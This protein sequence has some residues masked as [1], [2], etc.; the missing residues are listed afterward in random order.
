[1]Q[2]GESQDH[3]IRQACRKAVTH[4]LIFWLIVTL[5]LAAIVAY[6]GKYWRN[7]FAGPYPVTSAQLATMS[8]LAQEP[9][10]FVKVTGNK[11]YE[12]GIQ[13]ITTETRNGVEQRSYASADYYVLLVEGKLLPVKSTRKPGLTTTGRLQPVGQSLTDHL[14]GNSPEDQAT[15]PALLPV[16]VDTASYRKAG[17]ISLAFLA[18]Y[19]WILWYF[20]GRAWR[21]RR[22]I[23]QYPVVRAVEAWPNAPYAI[24]Q[25][26]QERTTA[27]RIVS[28]G[29]TV[30]ENYVLSQTIFGFQIF[31]VDTLLW[32]Y[33]KVTK[34]S[35]NMI[36]TG[37]THQAMLKFA[38]GEF[39]VQGKEAKVLELLSYLAQ[40]VP[41]AVMGY[42]PELES[43]YTKN[44]A[45]FAVAVE[46]RRLP[47]PPAAALP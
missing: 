11:L 37:K 22:N 7:F 8:D 3:W 35:V 5:S 6:H 36:P 47:P 31:R 15:R 17:Y 44:R 32:A 26:G 41:W 27:V 45:G 9:R 39:N 38:G 16:F 4:Q 40:R 34:N 14:F 12:T 24:D 43:F 18:L 33:R 20:A 21:Y 13:Q 28:G 19:L 30:T 29:T 2:S 25:A 10:E 46:E 42:T 1:M 23:A